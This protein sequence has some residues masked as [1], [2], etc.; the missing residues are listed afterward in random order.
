MTQQCPKQLEC[1]NGGDVVKT[2]QAM[3][4]W[5]PVNYSRVY[6]LLRPTIIKFSLLRLPMEKRIG[7]E[8]G[9]NF[10]RVPGIIEHALARV[11]SGKILY[12]LSIIERHFRTMYY[13]VW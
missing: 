2:S 8:L 4:W 1:I 6:H 9:E 3:Q 12:N 11:G 13:I 10:A 5:F 7:R